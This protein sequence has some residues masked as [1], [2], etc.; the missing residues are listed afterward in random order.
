MRLKFNIVVAEAYAA[1]GF[2]AADSR[3]VFV[4]GW[5]CV[6]ACVRICAR[7][8]MDG[9]ERAD[10]ISAGT[11]DVQIYAICCIHSRP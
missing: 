10:A 4:F 1:A 9:C 2:V 6:F 7:V 8:M 5:L 3:P 11:F